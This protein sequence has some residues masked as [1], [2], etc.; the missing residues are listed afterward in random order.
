MLDIETLNE[1][2]QSGEAAIYLKDDVLYFGA[3]KWLLAS[4]IPAPKIVP[5]PTAEFLASFFERH[6]N[7][8]ADFRVLTARPQSFARPSNDGR[9]YM[10]QP[11]DGFRPVELGSGSWGTLAY[12]GRQNIEKA[13][14]SLFGSNLVD[15]TALW[16]SGD[17][18]PIYPEDTKDQLIT[19][20]KAE[21]Y[22]FR[23]TSPSGLPRMV[24]VRGSTWRAMHRLGLRATVVAD[25]DR[26]EVP[27][28]GL[29][30]S[31]TPHQHQS[32]PSGL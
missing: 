29:R 27:H 24:C 22:L 14:P 17:V 12:S 16:R 1:L 10:F 9:D 2:L 32:F 20:R 31:Q 7:R 25:S 21:R 23:F 15:L 11:V 26:A 6:P 28:L 13:T 3:G 4:P 30:H 18:Q 8:S 19:K 5:P